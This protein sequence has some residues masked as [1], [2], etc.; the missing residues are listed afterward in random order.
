M[1]IGHDDAAG[2]ASPVEWVAT[3]H[4][5]VWQARQ[6]L[7]PVGFDRMPDL[8]VRPD[9]VGELI[10]GIACCFRK[11]GWTA[12]ELLTEDKREA[13]LNDLFGPGVGT[14]LT[15]CRM[16]IG[17]NDF[18][19]NWYSYD[20]TDGDF[21]RRDFSIEQDNQRLVPLGRRRGAHPP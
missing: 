15:L 7:E 1:Q 2:S 3:T 14:N 10:D 9:T 8:M 4:T 5:V 17:A 21:D 6:A 18:S 20:E 11:L 16:P 13:I 19:R 12:L